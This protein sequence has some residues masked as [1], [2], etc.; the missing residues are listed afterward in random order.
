VRV[1]IGS[2]RAERLGTTFTPTPPGGRDRFWIVPAGE[3]CGPV[4]VQALGWIEPVPGKRRT[5]R[6]R[7]PGCG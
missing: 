6:L 5:G 1:R 3:A 2:R 4:S 7:G